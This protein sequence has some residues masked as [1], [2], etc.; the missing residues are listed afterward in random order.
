MKEGKKQIL[1]E[2]DAQNGKYLLQSIYFHLHSAKC[3]Y[4]NRKLNYAHLT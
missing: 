3:L 4:L 1:T 2:E